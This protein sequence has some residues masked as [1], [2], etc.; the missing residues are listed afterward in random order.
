MSCYSHTLRVQQVH[1]P[2]HLRAGLLAHA[3]EVAL[4]VFE[5]VGRGEPPAGGITNCACGDP[6]PARER[7]CGHSPRLGRGRG[8]LLDL[9]LGFWRGLSVLIGLPWAS[10]GFLRPLPVLSSTGGLPSPYWPHERPDNAAQTIRKG[11]GLRDGE[12]E[13]ACA[14]PQS[15]VLAF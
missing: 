8:G 12:L 4:A 3:L 2:L 1:A 6:R 15:T 13:F 11:A 10:R 14:W 5:R 7:Y 9:R